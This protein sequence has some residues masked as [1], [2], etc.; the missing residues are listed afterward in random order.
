MK[1]LCLWGQTKLLSGVP[2]GS[3]FGPWFVNIRVAWESASL[4]LIMLRYV[5]WPTIF[6]EK[7]QQGREHF[8][9]FH[10]MILGKRTI[11][12]IQRRIPECRNYMHHIIE[13]DWKETLETR[14]WHR[15][16]QQSASYQWPQWHHKWITPKTVY[17]A[18][19]CSVD[20]E[21]EK[22]DEVY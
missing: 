8:S 14:T 7:N 13:H 6:V 22:K 5:V 17:I 9:H 12:K 21:T 18:H 16:W 4:L 19:T 1:T 15:C 10:G 11:T 2:Q 20:K 3:V